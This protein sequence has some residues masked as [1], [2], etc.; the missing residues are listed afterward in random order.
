MVCV[1]EHYRIHS[2]L[3]H[4]VK[5]KPKHNSELTQQ[6]GMQKRTTKRLGV[7]NEA[8]LLRVLS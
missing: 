5:L 8:G 7:T 6:D 4:A 3:T 1:Q 2:Q